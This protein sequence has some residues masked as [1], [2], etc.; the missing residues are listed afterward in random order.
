[1]PYGLVQQPRFIV[2]WLQ[3]YKYMGHL[4]GESIWNG[5]SSSHTEES[6]AVNNV[7]GLYPST[8]TIVDSINPSVA[9][10]YNYQIDSHNMR[11][12]VHNCN[13]FGVLGHNF[14]NFNHSDSDG[15][16]DAMVRFS[17]Y[18]DGGDWGHA[19]VTDDIKI[20]A[21]TENYNY[22]DIPFNGF[23]LRSCDGGTLEQL[24]RQV[25]LSLAVSVR[26]LNPSPNS[27]L[28]NSAKAGS[29]LW[30]RYFD[31]KSPD[32][33]MVMTIE[34]SSS[35]YRTRGGNDLVQQ[36]YRQPSWGDGRAWEIYPEESQLSK[37]GRSG[38]RVWS[39]TF[40]LEDSELFPESSSVD[41]RGSFN[42]E[43]LSEGKKLLDDDSFY[44][45]VIH[46]T[47]KHLPFIFMPNRN[48]ENDFAICKFI[49]N[50]KF[51]LIAPNRYQVSLK[52][53]EVW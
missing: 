49:N 50:F 3:W 26:N 11:F 20:N 31:V 23:T 7:I 46:R 47:G 38:R 30:G 16:H 35:K 33:N 18:T 21:E 2:D 22:T 41:Y 29:I 8:Q 19:I 17:Y 13:I 25:G 9:S 39:L 27:Q 4:K 5:T 10:G 52:F 32:V 51:N 42:S 43:L 53:K 45:S 12:P 15:I 44:S 14:G 36:N 1:M 28:E 34:T 37:L 48:D 40:T 24:P 6:T